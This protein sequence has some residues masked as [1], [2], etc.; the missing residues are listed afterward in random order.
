MNWTER[1]EIPAPIL[2]ALMSDSYSDMVKDFIDMVPRKTL[3]KVK[4][5]CFSVTTLNKSPRQRILLARHSQEMTL[6]PMDMIWRMWGRAVHSILESFPE[7]GDMIEVRDGMVIG[8]AFVHGQ[9]DR[10]VPRRGL[11]QDYKV[12]SAESALYE[13]RVDYEL[14]LNLLRVIFEDSGYKVD[15]LQN[16]FIYRNWK[17]NKVKEG[18][19]YP[20]APVAVVDIPI[21]PRQK[22]LDL[23][24]ERV[25]RHVE[26]EGL[27]D[28]DLPHCTAE[29]RWQSLPLHR[30]VKLNADGS[31]QKVAKFKSRSMIEVDDFIAQSTEEEKANLLLKNSERA[32]PKPTSEVLATVPKFIVQ[33][34][35]SEPV[36]CR[37]CEVRQFCSQYKEDIANKESWAI[38]GDDSN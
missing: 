14:Q 30:A 28:S 3:A 18:T 20:I 4:G 22:V 12:T 31:P 29:E 25:H 1:P 7:E 37:Y 13:S 21:W 27:S 8:R 5:K 35:P 38:D 9:A 10:F 15:K 24:E 16:V 23:V 26:A 11:L 2:K 34:L 17:A 36:K 6:D 19:L 32:K 33:T